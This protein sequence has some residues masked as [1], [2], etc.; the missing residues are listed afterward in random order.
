MTIPRFG[1]LPWGM[2]G[3]LNRL[4]DAMNAMSPIKGDRVV[5][6]NTSATG[7]NISLNT[8]VLARLLPARPIHYGLAQQFVGEAAGVSWSVDD[9]NR[10]EVHVK[11][12][13]TDGNDPVDDEMT[14][15]CYHGPY[16]TPNIRVGQ[17]IP[18]SYA[19]DGL[20]V[21]L[22][23]YGDGLIGD[24]KAH[25]RTAGGG[26][27]LT[28]DLEATGW[29]LADGSNGTVGCEGRQLVGQGT[30]VF[31]IWLDTL[32]TTGHAHAFSI[33]GV[34]NT[35]RDPHDTA[36]QLQTAEHVDPTRVI[37]WIERVN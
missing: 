29:A 18:F 10:V 2:A 11:L 33:S 21:T 6:V 35:F 19:I 22:T 20:P 37:Q 1:N 30:G 3:P 7:T 28:P 27:P 12:C 31:S 17:I 32:G 14:I 36:V 13:D 4:V 15:W 9:V 34:M 16:V 26:G 5:Q 25:R 24:I 8:N 23:D